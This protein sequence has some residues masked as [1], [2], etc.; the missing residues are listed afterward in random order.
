MLLTS[1]LVLQDS[2]SLWTQWIDWCIASN[3]GQIEDVFE[4]SSSDEVSVGCLG[5]C[6]SGLAGHGAW[7][8]LVNTVYM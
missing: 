1:V 8:G 4:V 2:L 3:P 5:S 7:P 6:M